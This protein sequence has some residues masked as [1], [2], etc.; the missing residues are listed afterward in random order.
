[1]TKNA[2]KARDPEVHQTR[3]GQPWHFGM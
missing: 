1:L 2:G 3:K